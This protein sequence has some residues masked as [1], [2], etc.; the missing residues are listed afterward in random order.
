MLHWLSTLK[1]AP[2]WLSATFA[3]GSLLVAIITA[4]IAVR[5]ARAK[6]REAQARSAEQEK[7]REMLETVVKY[8]KF[9]QHIKGVDDR[10]ANVADK[11]DSIADRT[12]KAVDAGTTQITK[13]VE[14]LARAASAAN[15]IAN[16]LREIGQVAL[17]SQRDS[18]RAHQQLLEKAKPDG[19]QGIEAPLSSHTRSP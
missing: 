18:L 8:G 19:A 16:Q 15:D 5:E 1:D 4:T 9:V 17:R 6:A 3:L 2:P 14:S 10:I 12:L 7:Y 13:S 11:L